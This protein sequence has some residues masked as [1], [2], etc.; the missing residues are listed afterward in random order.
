MGHKGGMKFV[1]NRTISCPYQELNPD[2][3]VRP[4]RSLVAIPT[5]LSWLVTTATGGGGGIITVTKK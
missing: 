3:S 1:E 2:F 4:P 5:E